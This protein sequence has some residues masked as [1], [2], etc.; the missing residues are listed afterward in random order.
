MAAQKACPLAC[1]HAEVRSS[2]PTE[3]TCVPSFIQAIH[4][5]IAVVQGMYTIQYVCMCMCVC[6]L[7]LYVVKLY[8]VYVI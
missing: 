8:V 2:I 5:Q 6:I 3:S 7:Y 1:K 4:L